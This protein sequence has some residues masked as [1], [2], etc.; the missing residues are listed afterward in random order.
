M[1]IILLLEK[2]RQAMSWTSLARQ[3]R[4]VVELLDNRRPCLKKNVV[5]IEKK[6]SSLSSDLHIHIYTHMYTFLLHVF[7]MNTFT[8]ITGKKVKTLPHFKGRH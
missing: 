7:H 4:L 6:H 3:L 8:S 5:N 1:L 2:W